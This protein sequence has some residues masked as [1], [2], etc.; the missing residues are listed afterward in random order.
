MITEKRG[1]AAA[2]DIQQWAERIIQDAGGREAVSVSHDPE[3][4]TYVLRLARGTRVL[5]FRLSEA[6]AHTSGREAECEKTLR[7]KLKNL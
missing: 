7:T 1:D 5:L 3:S 4:N 2:S 6:Q